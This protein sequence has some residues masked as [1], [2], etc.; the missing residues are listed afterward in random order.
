MKRFLCLVLGLAALMLPAAEAGKPCPPLRVAKWYFR[1]QV[2][3]GPLECAVLFDVTGSNAQNVL[4]MLEALQDEFRVPIRAVAVNP[5]RQADEFCSATGPYTIGL[6]ADDKLKTRNSLAET[7]SLFPYAVLSRNGEVVWSGHPTELESVI[8]LVKVDKFSLSK[9]R[10]VESLRKELQMAIQSGLPHVVASTA[11]K[12]L[13]EAPSDRIAIQAKIMALSSG[14]A[15]R[16]VPA[17]IRRVCKE[18]P[19]DLRLRVMQLDFLL[20]EGDPDG[21]LKAVNQFLQDF[22]KPD[23]RLVRPI[24]FIIENAPYGSLMPGLAM[25]LARRAYDGVK[26]APKTLTYAIACETLARVEAEHGHFSEAVKLQESALPL[27]EKTPQEAAAKARL[28]YYRE[29]LK[30]SAAK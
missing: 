4:R 13:K 30:S 23:A 11:D 8:E 3:A 18:N 9:Q 26:S 20:R 22:P 17:F 19:Q 2:P 10:R 5:R 7:E 12:I 14:G 24:A 28:Q 6:A 21:F 16:E 1:S 27:R 29:L 25:T 15:G